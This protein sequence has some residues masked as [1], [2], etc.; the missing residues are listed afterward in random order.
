LW[1]L[2]HMVAWVGTRGGWV[3]CLVGVDLTLTQGFC[4]GQKTQ[5]DHSALSYDNT[6]RGSV[7]HSFLHLGLGKRKSFFCHSCL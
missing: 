6:L 3:E 4:D 5:V 2:R 7:S 1:G